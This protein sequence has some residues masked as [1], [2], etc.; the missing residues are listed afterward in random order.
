MRKKF[1][2]SHTRTLISSFIICLILV[3][4]PAFTQTVSLESLEKETTGKTVDGLM[5]V[6]SSLIKDSFIPMTFWQ[7]KEYLITFVPAYFQINQVYDDPEVRGEDLKGWAAGLGGGYAF[8][9]RLLFYGILAVQNFKGN[10]SGKMYQDPLPVI[11]ADISYRSVFFSPGAGYEILSNKWFSLPLYLGPFILH[12]N[13]DV[14]MPRES[15]LSNSFE[16]KASGS[17]ILYGLSG[18]FAVSF[19]I[20]DK[21]KITPYYLY[22]RSLNKPEAD[23]D[24]TFTPPFPFSATTATESLDTESINASMVGLSVTLVT[25]KNLSFSASIGGYITS[26][27]GWYNEKFLNGLE[28]K[29]IVFAVTYTNS[30]TK[31]E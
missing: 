19:K 26:E 18:G 7:E 20:L 4:T 2:F 30:N 3:H 29:S 24:M 11:E 1:L 15:Y 16:A 8:N 21:L 13:L 28:M 27:T 14:E 6:S 23:A 22:I 17:G 9:E 25:T 10:I 31:E 5:N 12:Y